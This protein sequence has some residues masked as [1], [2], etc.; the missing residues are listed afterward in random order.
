VRERFFRGYCRLPGTY[1]QTI[2]IFNNKKEEIYDVYHD[3]EQLSEKKKKAILTYYD[4]FYKI[5]NDPKQAQKKIMTIAKS[6]K[7]IYTKR[8]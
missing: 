6:I 2:A 5:I 8:K 1:E 3:F 7:T 4:D